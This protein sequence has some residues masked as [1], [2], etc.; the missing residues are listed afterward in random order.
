MALGSGLT[1]APKQLQVRAAR[2]PCTSPARIQLSA[3]PNG[4]LGLDLSDSGILL[5]SP[6][7]AGSGLAGS[8]SAAG[9]LRGGAGQI[10]PESLG[11]GRVVG[12]VER[13]DVERSGS[14]LPPARSATMDRGRQR[15]A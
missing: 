4:Y 15:P 8:C 14:E 11:G 6:L 2:A 13:Y 9:P 5:S 7:L 1:R 10:S 3:A 12:H